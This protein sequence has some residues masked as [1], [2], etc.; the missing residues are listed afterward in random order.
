[1]RDMTV[2][3]V[4]AAHDDG[5]RTVVDIPEHDIH[6]QTRCVAGIISPVPRRFVGRWPDC[7]GIRTGYLKV[8][9]GDADA[10]FG[11]WQGR[12]IDALSYQNEMRDECYSVLFL[13][14]AGQ[15]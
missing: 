12:G 3:S 10:A 11:L 14:P 7:L 5:M 2:Y 6:G 4:D 13:I 9:Q 15:S 8:I 1:M